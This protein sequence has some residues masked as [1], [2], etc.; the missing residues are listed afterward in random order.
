MVLSGFV[1][2]ATL[3][4]YVK[5]GKQKELDNRFSFQIVMLDF[6]K[7][8]SEFFEIHALK[9]NYFENVA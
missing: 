5:C 1:L 6:S 4:S 7:L 9:R 2:L 8:E 3:S